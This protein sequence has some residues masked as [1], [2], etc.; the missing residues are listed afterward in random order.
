M[1]PKEK[2]AIVKLLVNLRKLFRA[3]KDNTAQRYAENIADVLSD[4]KDMDDAP[5]TN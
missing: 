5:D 2:A 1:S 3:T 4:L